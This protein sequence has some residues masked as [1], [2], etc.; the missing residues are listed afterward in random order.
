[1]EKRLKELDVNSYVLKQRPNSK[2][3]PTLVTNVK[4]WV[5]HT[6]YPLGQG[7][8]PEYIRSMRS[9]VGLDADR[10]GTAYEDG[11]CVFRCLMY[12]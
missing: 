10:R 7:L 6:N 9:V 2:Y 4:W 5:S 8:L 11:N 1:M 12:H 3:V